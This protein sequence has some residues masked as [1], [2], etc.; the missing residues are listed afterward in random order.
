MSGGTNA[1]PA[2]L[3]LNVFGERLLGDAL[4]D[5]FDILR[6]HEA[7][8]PD[9]LLADRGGDVV[10]V[11]SFAMKADLLDRLPNLR[12]IAVPGA[13]FDAVPVAEARA[14]GITV[15]NAGDAH[16]GDVADHAVAMVLGFLHRIPELHDTVLSGG[17][18]TNGVPPRRR[19]MTAQRVGILG[20]GNIGKEIAKRMAPFGCE[21][22]WWSPSQKDV[23]WPRKESVEALAEWSTVLIVAARGDAKGLVD[24]AALKALGPEGL[25]CNISRGAVIDEDAMIAAL[26]DGSLG[27]AA[28]DVFETEPTPPERWK[29]VPNVLLAPHYAGLAE[30]AGQALR[31][32]AIAN[33]TTVLDGGPVVNEVTG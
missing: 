6:L 4:T 8:D 31:R 24:A 14:R 29:D 5:R 26:K 12:L 22:A 33:L 13:G 16:S 32:A 9:A 21:I 19:G 7:E 20:L 3:L 23:P 28:L 18:K 27:G 2:L 30:T 17:W 15:A 10:A 11:L 1:K 25:I